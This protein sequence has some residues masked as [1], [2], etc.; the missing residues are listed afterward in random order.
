[1]ASDSL[2]INLLADEIEKKGV[3]IFSCS[4]FIRIKRST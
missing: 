3:Q 1:M 4:G 2:G